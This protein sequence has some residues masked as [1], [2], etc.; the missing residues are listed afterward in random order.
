MTL[1]WFSIKDINTLKTVPP[2]QKI[3]LLLLDGFREIIPS[4]ID[5]IYNIELEEI[6]NKFKKM[7]D[8]HKQDVETTNLNCLEKVRDIIEYEKEKREEKSF[9]F[10]E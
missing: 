2:L 9:K 3:L 8:N 1:L 4:E 10:K 7:I 5:K 6:D